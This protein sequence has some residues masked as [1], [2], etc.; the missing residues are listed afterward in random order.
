MKN[1]CIYDTTL[2]DGTQ[3]EGISFSVADKIRIAERL[4]DFGIHYVEGGWPGS[5]PKDI[6]FFD[7]ISRV[8]LKHAKI[9]AFG[10][11]RRAHVAVEKEENIQK[12]LDAQTPVVT[13]FGKSWTLH[14]A[15]VLKV[16]KDENLRMI[17]ESVGYLKSKGRE[18]V[19]D[20][21]HFFDGYKE[22]AAYA[23]DTLKTAAASG[24]S[25]VVLCDT[26]GG[27][28][29][30]EVQ[31]IVRQVVSAVDCQVGI[32][33]HNDTGLAVANSIIAVLNGA[34]QVQGTI[35]GYGERSGNADLCTI[36]PNLK[37][38]LG[39]NCIADKKLRELVEVSRF[40]DELAN[41]RPHDKQPYVGLS[42]FA[43]KGG[44]HV[45]AVEKNPKTF[46][47]VDP[48]LVGNKRRILISELA[49]K[50]NVLLKTSEL[51][52]SFAK[53]M[54]VTKE[55][56]ETLKKREHEGY[57]YEAAGGSFELLVKKAMKHHKT[58]F[59]LEGFRVIVEKR[60]DDRL[61][62]E[63]TIKVKVGD[64][65][66]HAAAEGD[67]PVNALDGALRKA[68]GQF[69]PEISAVRLADFKVRVLDAK[70]GTAAKVRVLIESSDDKEIWGTVG[71][72]ENIIEASWQALV[73]SVEYKLLKGSK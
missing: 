25:T 37:I 63:A 44:M 34:V 27:T 41:F 26:N 56:I 14:V 57:E 47:H 66:V 33:V 42:A 5:N 39:Y 65:T 11:T 30:N 59:K 10:S 24:A 72:S 21:E 64:E 7:K 36:I 55:I 20:A 61:I 73:D 2:R 70:D 9:A 71:V 50:S 19:Y 38:K 43:H 51:G 46:E 53:D 16:S 68:L 17:K 40:V 48:G 32:H 13:I 22:D 28:M 1:V 3:G 58:F 4:D 69:Y 23:L 45:N 35:N 52:L 62:S 6:E 60:E 12:L 15:D 49:G 29:P 8:K 67:G 31:E 54:H 18:V